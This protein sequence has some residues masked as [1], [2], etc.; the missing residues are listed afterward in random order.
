MA[1]HGNAWQRVATRDQDHVYTPPLIRPSTCLCAAAVFLQPAPENHTCTSGSNWVISYADAMQSQ[2][3]E[4]QVN[5]LHIKH[6]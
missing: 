5:A 6:R 2:V 1:T 4:R 3:T